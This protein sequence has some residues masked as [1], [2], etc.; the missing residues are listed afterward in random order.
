MG[1]IYEMIYLLRWERGRGSRRESEGVV[2]GMDDDDKKKIEDG[3]REEED[4]GKEEEE[5]K[6]IGIGGFGDG[7]M[8]GGVSGG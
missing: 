5:G 4:E 3:W 8:G 6:R 2:V 1:G 7:P